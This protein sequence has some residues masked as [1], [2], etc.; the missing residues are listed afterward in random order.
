[1]NLDLV[2]VLGEGNS[3]LHAVNRQESFLKEK[4]ESIVKEVDAHFDGVELSEGAKTA[5]QDDDGLSGKRL[6]F[7][8]KFVSALVQFTNYALHQYG[9]V[10]GASGKQG[11]LALHVLA[12]NSGIDLPANLVEN[13]TEV[14]ETFK[15]AWALDDTASV[16]EIFNRMVRVYQKEDGSYGGEDPRVSN[17]L[18]TVNFTAAEDAAPGSDAPFRQALARVT[19][20]LFEKQAISREPE[21]EDQ[22]RVLNALLDKLDLNGL[23]QFRDD[24]WHLI[25]EALGLEADAGTEEMYASMTRVFEG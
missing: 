11:Y 13:R 8:D 17:T 20:S 21:A 16:D 25:A 24:P 7:D 6:S 1:M 4:T 23:H 3:P 2:A 9:F 10:G 5:Y 15:E 14:L 12:K 19:Q 22:G 18:P